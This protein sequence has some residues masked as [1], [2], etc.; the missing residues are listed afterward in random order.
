VVPSSH[1]DRL[2]SLF[3]DPLI[4][5]HSGGHVVPGDPQLRDSVAAF[6][7]ERARDVAAFVPPS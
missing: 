2:A 6:L 5:R 3:R 1:S 7:Q 4:L